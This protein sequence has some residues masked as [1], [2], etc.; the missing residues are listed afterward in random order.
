MIER[1]LT[2]I[3]ILLRDYLECF[4]HVLQSGRGEDGPCVAVT[5]DRHLLHRN[6]E[7]FNMANFVQPSTV[8]IYKLVQPAFW[9][10]SSLFV[11]CTKKNHFT[12][13]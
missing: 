2:Q 9:H 3:S 13:S 12:T 8:S 6:L 11:E 7:K 10:I 4:R 1:P 5:A